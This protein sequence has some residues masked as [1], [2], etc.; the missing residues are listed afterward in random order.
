M[1]PLADK[2]LLKE[3][4]MKYQQLAVGQN[5]ATTTKSLD[6]YLQDIGKTGTALQYDIQLV[7]QL[8]N[9]N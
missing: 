4:I 1:N 6:R 7:R 2:N 3:A 8:R 9:S 5:L